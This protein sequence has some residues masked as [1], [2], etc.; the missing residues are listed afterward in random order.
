MPVDPSSDTYW[1]MMEAVGTI[2]AAAVATLGLVYFEILR[3]LFGQPSFSIKFRNQQ[4]YSSHTDIILG[5]TPPRQ[6][7]SMGR[8]IRLGIENAS[9]TA[10][11]G[12]RVKLIRLYFDDGTRIDGFIPY[13]LAWV[14]TK[15][16]RREVLAVKEEA[17]VELLVGIKDY[18]EYWWLQPFDPT[19]SQSFGNVPSLPT[20]L[21]PPYRCYLEVAAYA[22]NRSR[23]PQSRRFEVNYEEAAKLHALRMRAFPPGP[24]G[25]WHRL[26]LSIDRFRSILGR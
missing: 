17:F 22:E 11:R 1:A 24:I 5:G 12:V 26:R 13:D 19:S 20:S 10:A 8:T 4:P 18:P 23:P 6:H 2:C 9:R 15:E 25:L 21:Q 14:D 16:T 3:P 7:S